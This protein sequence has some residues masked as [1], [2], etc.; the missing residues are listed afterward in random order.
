LDPHGRDLKRGIWGA[1]VANPEDCWRDG[2]EK[3]GYHE[4][5]GIEPL[6]GAPGRNA[7]LLVPGYDVVHFLDLTDELSKLQVAHF[8]WRSAQ[9]GDVPI[10]ILKTSNQ[11]KSSIQQAMFSA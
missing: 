1:S 8:G 9:F 5:K 10:K 4:A 6:A 3:T 2:E 11:L 7:D